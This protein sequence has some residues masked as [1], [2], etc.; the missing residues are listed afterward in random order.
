M[1]FRVSSR[2]RAFHA[3]IISLS[4]SHCRGT[5]PT[6]AGESRGA[7][8][9]AFRSSATSDLHYFTLMP[10]EREEGAQIARGREGIN[11]LPRETR[12]FRG[13]LTARVR[14]S[15]PRS[16]RVAPLLITRI[17]PPPSSLLSR[18]SSP[19]CESSWT[20]KISRSKHRLCSDLLSFCVRANRVSRRSTNLLRLRGRDDCDLNLHVLESTSQSVSSV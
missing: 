10:A 19:V 13:F 4:L 17:L 9:P 8:F 6:L 11:A 20:R 3:G 12:H 7:P 18:K 16:P 2:L 14:R 5:R 15:L 1:R